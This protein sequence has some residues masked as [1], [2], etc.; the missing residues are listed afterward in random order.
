MFYLDPL[1]DV[2][3]D[4]QKFLVIDQSTADLCLTA[5]IPAENRELW[6]QEIDELDD[7]EWAEAEGFLWLA[8][9]Q[10]TAIGDVID[11]GGA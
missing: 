8:I 3:N 4:P 11:G 6:R 7:A 5:L 2:E 10:L 1:K 9:G